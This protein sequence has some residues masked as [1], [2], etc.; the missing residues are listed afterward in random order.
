M[1]K[2]LRKFEVVHDSTIVDVFPYGKGIGARGV[3]PET[4]RYD[5]SR[6]EAKADAE[7]KALEIAEGLRHDEKLDIWIHEVVRE[8]GVQREVTHKVR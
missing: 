6:A 1:K 3:C 8:W 7:A 4:Q 5:I 2:H